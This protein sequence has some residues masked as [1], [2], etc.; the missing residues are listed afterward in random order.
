VAVA[1]WATA[2]IG[3]AFALALILRTPETLRPAEVG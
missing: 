3:S 1:T 2:G